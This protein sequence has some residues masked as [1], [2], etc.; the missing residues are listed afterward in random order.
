MSYHSAHLRNERADL[1]AVNTLVVL[2]NEMTSLAKT[3]PS[4]SSILRYMTLAYSYDNKYIIIGQD[5]YPSHIVPCFGSAYSQSKD[6]QDTP[7][8]RIIY[9]H[10]NGPG[11][12]GGSTVRNMIR[13]N[14]RLIQ[15]GYLFVN[16]DFSRSRK[17]TDIRN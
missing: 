4:V 3:Q 1:K 16:S 14:W 7:T 2:V 11:D 13:E 17:R 5:P 15:N 8:T 10:F 9:E 12:S 6:T